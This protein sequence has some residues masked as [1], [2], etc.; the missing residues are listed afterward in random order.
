MID[1]VEVT[2][3]H[4]ELLASLDPL[5]PAMAPLEAADGEVL[6]AVQVG[7]SA[8]IGLTRTERLEPDAEL[9]LWSPLRRNVLTTRLAGPDRCAALDAL[10]ARWNVL[11][12]ERAEG[13]DRDSAA[14]VTV[15]SR[16]VEPVR[17]LVLHGFAPLIVVA[18]RRG[19]TRVGRPSGPAEVRVASEDDLD[20]LARLATELHLGDTR[21]GLVTERPGATAVLRAGLA[22][23]LRQAPG[24]TWVS[25]SDGA[26]TGFAQVQPP[27]QAG[28]VAPMVA[29][30][31]AG[32]FGY[33]FVAP[34]GRGAGV[35]AALVAAAHRR[36]DEAGVDVTVLHHALPSP[37]STPFWAQQGYWPL[38]TTW[39][40]R[41][42][43][44]EAKATASL[45]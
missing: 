38:W 16:D 18:G 23:Q 29:S 22:E 31:S 5:L 28:W 8:A 21:F 9:A 34:G 45:P 26:V 1:P 36:L 17:A 14:L 32:Y 3:R 15:P 37:L 20:A 33:L 43:V 40:R 42:A 27:D 30:S 41:P 13:G 4:A 11:L 24:W 25:V 39:Q 12:Q 35:G 6:L 2:A 7:D 19:G 44:A 10:L